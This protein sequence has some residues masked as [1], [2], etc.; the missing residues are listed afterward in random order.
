MNPVIFLF[1]Y[2]GSVGSLL[3]ILLLGQSDYHKNGIV[4]FLNRVITTIPKRILN[5]C[6]GMCIPGGKDAAT[7]FEDVCCN[8]RNPVMQIVYLTLLSVGCSIWYVLVYP[9]IPNRYL[10]SWHQ[11]TTIITLVFN[12]YIFLKASFTDPGTIKKENNEHFRNSFKND[13]IL[14]FDD[15]HCKTCDIIKPARSKHCPICKRCVSKFDHHCIWLNTDVGELNY[16][17][18]QMFLLSNCFTFLYGNL[19]IVAYLADIVVSNNLFGSQFQTPDGAKH[20]A[21]VGI[22]L[23]YL[24]LNQIVICGLL[25]FGVACTLMLFGFWVYHFYLTCQNKTTNE[26]FKW[27]D[28]FEDIDAIKEDLAEGKKFNF[29]NEKKPWVRKRLKN[30]E[31]HAKAGTYPENIYNKGLIGNY[32]EVF[33]PPSENEKKSKFQ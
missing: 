25:F 16:R 32:K 20:S 26:S 18:F 8:N 17:Y 3:Y 21:S 2:T 7:Y 24:I 28:S 12:Y 22:V 33:F 9:S 19:T 23:Q 13:E 1:C 4:G 6:C 27:S 14:Y 29:D 10:S 31:K 30:F 15:R 5:F 11:Y